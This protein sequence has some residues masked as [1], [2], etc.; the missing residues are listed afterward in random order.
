[1]AKH[2][3]VKMT[4]YLVGYDEFADGN[5]FDPLCIEG[6][7]Q[8]RPLVYR[9]ADVEQRSVEVDDFEESELNHCSFI[10]DPVRFQEVLD[11][12]EIRSTT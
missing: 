10:D 7:L 3:I 1:M 9:I 8:H 11:G 4:L 2:K 12:S 6:D 5:A